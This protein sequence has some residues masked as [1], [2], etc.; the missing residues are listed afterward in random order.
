MRVVKYFTPEIKQVGS[1]FLVTMKIM[2]G[3]PIRKSSKVV[4]KPKPT[5]YLR[6][7]TK[8]YHSSMCSKKPN[9]IFL[10]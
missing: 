4:K 6:M 3:P 2:L 8:T 7:T 10:L 9:D 5:T 1:N